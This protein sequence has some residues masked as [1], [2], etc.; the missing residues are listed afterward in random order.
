VS[1]AQEEFWRGEFGSNYVDRNRVD[2][3]ARI[4]FW[5]SII[6]ATDCKSVCEIGCNAGWNLRAIRSVDPDISVHGID[7]NEKALLEAHDEGLMVC[8]LPASELGKTYPES[9]DLVCS[10]GVLIHIPPDQISDVLESMIAAST[11]YVLA[12]EYAAETEEA[13]EYRGH[14][15][16][17]WRR[18]FGK[19]LVEKGL[20][21]VVWGDAG[22][23]FDSCGFWLLSR[24]S[25]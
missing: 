17:L 18:P 25:A 9:F 23:G 1:T 15:E 7:V 21:P 6:E 4:P 12:V 19:M 14:T 2:W 22:E 11:K 13:V 20:K 8:N 3:R 16:R 24:D 5:R 10:V